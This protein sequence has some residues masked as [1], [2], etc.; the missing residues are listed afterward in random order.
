RVEAR[1]SAAGGVATSPLRVAVV[2]EHAQFVAPQGDSLQ[3]ASD[4]GESL[5]RLLDWASDPAILGAN[6][7]TVLVAE[8]LNDL[9]RQIVESPY[10]AKIHLGL[11]DEAEALEYFRALAT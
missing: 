4:L 11:P 10:V 3:L 6:I 7:A 1:D 9:H 2:V 8:S 5:I